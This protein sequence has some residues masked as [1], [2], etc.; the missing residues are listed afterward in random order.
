[1]HGNIY[2]VGL[3]AAGKST[4]GR[5]LAERMR[6]PFIDTDQ[7]LE[8]K[9]GVSV[10]RIFAIEGESGFRLREE[11]LLAEISAVDG[12]QTATAAKPGAI[13]ATGGGVILRESNRLAMRQSGAVVYLRVELEALRARLAGSVTRPLM[14]GADHKTKLAELWRQRDPLYAAAADFV[15]EVGAESVE[16][17]ARRIHAMVRPPAI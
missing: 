8:E 13:V 5:K 17:T 11:K 14:Q 3:M 4:V 12:S 16:Q 2:L 1:M 6:R 15:V 7:A 9:T 10:S